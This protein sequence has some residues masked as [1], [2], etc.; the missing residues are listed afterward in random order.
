MALL[1]CT[2]IT[3][4]KWY[5]HPSKDQ[6]ICYGT[7]RQNQFFK[8]K[9]VTIGNMVKKHL[10]NRPSSDGWHS[11]KKTSSVLHKKGAGRPLVNSDR[12]EVVCEAFQC[13]PS[14]PTCCPS[15]E[16]CKLPVRVCKRFYAVSWSCTHTKSR[17][18]KLSNLMTGVIERN[19]LWTC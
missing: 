3:N 10:D 9:D 14:K 17:L 5:F 11:F 19:L 8:C 6:H 13:S 2:Q 18:C 7:G 12:V 15:R 4:A 1:K 16:N